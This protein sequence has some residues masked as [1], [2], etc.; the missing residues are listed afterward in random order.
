[1]LEGL[2][3]I[4]FEGLGPGPFCG[5]LMADLGAEVTVVHRRD[6]MAMPGLSG[7]SLLDR[8]KRSI[9]LD[10]K[11]PEDRDTAL[12]LLADADALIEGNRPGVME[13]LGLG[14]AECHAVNPKLVYGRM[15]GWGQSGPLAKQ[16]GHD[17]NYIARSGALWYSSPPGTPPFSPPTLVGDIGGGAMYLAVG[18]LAGVLRARATGHGTVV[19]AAIVD[20]SAHMMALL[21]TMRHQGVFKEE[22]GD[23]ILDGP[24]W[25]RS[26]RTLDGKYLVLQSLEPKFYALLLEGFGLQDDQAFIDGHYDPKAWPVLANRLTDLIAT[27]PLAHW[28]AIFGQT[29]A[30]V[31]PVNSPDEAARD[32]HLAARGTWL[33]EPLQPAPA[34][35]FDGITRTPG[36]IPTRGQHSD[37]IRARLA[38]SGRKSLLS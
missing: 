33:T 28:E 15:T 23:S 9:V 19:D 1:M 7:D 36:P 2:R 25:T 16:A 35:R 10:L 30:C 22:R 27:Q 29:D 6:H 31:A 38:N 8:G 13:R 11:S 26:Y 37:E 20:G 4:E 5:M 3:I 21:M 14:P 18:I 24:H 17:L 32:P 12:A 34:P